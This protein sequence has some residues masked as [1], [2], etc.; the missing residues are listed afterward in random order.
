MQDELYTRFQEEMDR[1]VDILV[2]ASLH[3]L[4][5]SRNFLPH[6]A[7][8]T[9]S[10]KVALMMGLK[11][12]E[13]HLTNSEEVLPRLYGGLRDM[14]RKG[15]ACSVATAENVQVAQDGGKFVDAIKVVYEN[16]AGLCVAFYAPYRKPFI[17]GHKALPMFANPTK[18]EIVQDWKTVGP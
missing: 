13:N 7:A 14:V 17:G 6:G 16:H 1:I 5:S 4:N 9:P 2:E 10:G 18:P 11:E 12:T 3:F 8:M 15:E